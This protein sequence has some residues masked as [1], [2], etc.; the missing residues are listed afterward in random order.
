MQN[1]YF[2]DNTDSNGYHEVHTG[3]CSYL[4]SVANRTYIGMFNCCSEAIRTAKDKYPSYSFDG[5]FFCCNS[6]HKG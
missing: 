5:C 1:Y 4:P 2:N 6:C 3:N